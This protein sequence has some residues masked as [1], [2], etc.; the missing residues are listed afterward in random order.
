MG[1]GSLFSVRWTSGR[2]ATCIALSQGTAW[3]WSGKPGDMRGAGFEVGGW[4]G[5]ALLW[6]PEWEPAQKV[7]VSRPGA[8]T[9]T[10]IV[11]LS[12]RVPMY[13]PLLLLM[14]GTGLLWWRNRPSVRRARLGQCPGCG[15]DLAGSPRRC[16]ECGREV[17]GGA[18]RALLRLLGLRPRALPL[19]GRAG[20]APT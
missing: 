3:C 15:Y 4:S 20:A 19:S 9:A 2:G 11:G 5:D 10:Q 16:P 7:W 18:I 8:R 14:A 1:V 6:R 17:A 13:L 12:V